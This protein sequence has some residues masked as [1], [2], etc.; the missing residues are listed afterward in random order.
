L[1]SV[2]I[3]NDIEIRTENRVFGRKMISLNSLKENFDD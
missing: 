2:E 1:A 3:M